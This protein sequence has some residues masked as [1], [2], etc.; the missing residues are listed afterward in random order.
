MSALR[1]RVITAAL[2]LPLVLW[3]ILALPSPQFSVVFAIVCLLGAWE[4]AALSGWDSTSRRALYVGGMAVG[5][6]GTHY[7]TGAPAGLSAVLVVALLWW[8]FALLMVLARQSGREW[9]GL[10][11]GLRGAAGWLV[12]IPAW[13]ALV[14]LHGRQEGGPYLVL[15]LL[16]LVWTA[17]A[18]AF[19]VG[20][21]WGRR[22]LA[23]RVSPGKSW[24]G[25][26]GGLAGVAAVATV[27]GVLLG[28]TP[29]RLVLFVGLALITACASV[30]GD[31]T[32]SLFKR[33]AGL[34]DSGRL[35]PGHGGV[36]DRID[37]LTAAG[38]VFALGILWLGGW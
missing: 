35:L 30:L 31:L 27:T 38:P 16:V 25:V 34:K 9:A 1:Q 10:S 19:F 23:S 6:L 29:A 15:F 2:L 26:I 22:R 8:L 33:Q 11:P 4:W 5:L 7:L 3:G 12:L 13:L 17:D 32:E 18:A 28:L 37:S 24:E 14:Y 21:R 20:R 36:L